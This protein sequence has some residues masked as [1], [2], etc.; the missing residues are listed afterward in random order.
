MLEQL[1]TNIRAP[2]YWEFQE[3]RA[4]GVFIASRSGALLCRI[5]PPF[6]IILWDKKAGCEVAVDVR[7]LPLYPF[8]NGDKG[9]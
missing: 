3:R 7:D 4:S 2:K 1:P 8:V 5:E 9:H 6:H